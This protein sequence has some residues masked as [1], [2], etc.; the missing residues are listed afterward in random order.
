MTKI[1]LMSAVAS[2]AI[3][4][5]GPP[6]QARPDAAESAAPAQMTEWSAVRKR[7]V[8]RHYP[9]PA[10]AWRAPAYGRLGDPSL[11]PDGRPYPRPRSLGGGCVYDE[12]YGRFTACPNE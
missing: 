3:L 12:G 7:R 6:A 1:G 8:V 10:Y 2:L 11:G 4:S 5:A 9:K